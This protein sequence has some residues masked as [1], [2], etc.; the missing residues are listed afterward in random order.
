LR[1]TSFILARGYD[2]DTVPL[3]HTD[4]QV[5]DLQTEFKQDFDEIIL[6][7]QIIGF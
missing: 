6:K 2:W 1:C 7:Y 5:T 3:I 4:N